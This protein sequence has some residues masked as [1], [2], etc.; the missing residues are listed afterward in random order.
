MDLSSSS[1]SMVFYELHMFDYDLTPKEIELY[2]QRNI[3]SR[4]PNIPD[5]SMHERTELDYQQ[6]EQEKEAAL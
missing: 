3:D 5:I 2:I 4:Y 1:A 6:L